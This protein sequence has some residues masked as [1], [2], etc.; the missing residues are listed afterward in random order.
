MCFDAFGST[1]R[2]SARADAMRVGAMRS[3]HR[4]TLAVLCLVLAAA[5]LPSAHAKNV[6]MRSMIIPSGTFGY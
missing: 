6:C 2:A 5:A 3:G 4:A 1:A